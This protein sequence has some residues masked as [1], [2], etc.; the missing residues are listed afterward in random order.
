MQMYKLSRNNAV[1]GV[2]TPKRLGVPK[3]LYLLVFFDDH[4]TPN[5]FNHHR[6]YV[7]IANQLNIVDLKCLLWSYAQT[8]RNTMICWNNKQNS[9]EFNYH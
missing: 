3:C 6:A 9:F 8:S 7:N 4:R 1:G 5:G 2:I